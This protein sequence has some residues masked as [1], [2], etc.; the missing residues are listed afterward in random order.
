MP[1]IAA[2]MGPG[3]PDCNASR[4]LDAFIAAQAS[5]GDGNDR[6]ASNGANTSATIRARW[7]R[8]KRGKLHQTSP[9]PS[10]PS[11]SRTRTSNAT[12]LAN[13]RI[14][15]ATVRPSGISSATGSTERIVTGAAAAPG[16]DAASFM[17]SR[18]PRASASVGNSRAASWAPPPAPSSMAGLSDARPYRSMMMF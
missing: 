5:A 2:A 8:P 3:S 18:L 15:F 16:A 13:A 17:D 14:G 7:R 9:H 12:T 4:R 6:P 11:A 1:A 10:T